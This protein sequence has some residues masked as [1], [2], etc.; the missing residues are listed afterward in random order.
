MESPPQME[1]G[2]E[3]VE[4]QSPFTLAKTGDFERLMPVVTKDPSLWSQR[5]EGDEHTLLHWAALGADAAFLQ[6]GLDSRAEVDARSANGQTP[7]MWAALRGRLEAA[8]LLLRAGA[9]IYGKDSL[10][11][12]PMVLA[13]QHQQHAMMVLLMAKGDR[14]R[15]LVE[16][17]NN[18]CGPVHWAAYKG[19]ITSL[20]LLD[21]FDADMSVVDGTRM[22]PLHRAVQA[23]KGDVLEFL[24]DKQV[25]PGAIDSQGHT[26]I[27]LA[28]ENGDKVMQRMLTKL[29]E[30]AGAADLDFA[31]G[32]ADPE[33]AGAILKR[34]KPDP[35]DKQ[36]DDYKKM[37]AHNGAAT[38][39]LVSV[40]LALFQYLTDI[41]TVSWT[42][43][44]TLA[45]MFELGVP[46][47]I[48][49]FFTVMF[50][51]PGKVPAR[52]KNNSA[53]E[54]YMK[55]VQTDVKSADFSKI[56]TTTWVLKG[57][58]TK[59]CRR[60][61]ACVDEFDHFCGWLN[62]AIGKGNH[63]AFVILALVE[64]STQFIHLALCW[65]AACK[66]VPNE[67]S[68]VNWQLGIWTEYPLTGL[69]MIMHCFTSPGIM[70]LFLNH[71]RMVAVNITTNEMMNL[72]RYGHFWKMKA[73][74]GKEFDNPFDK[75]TWAS[76]C[77]D[78]WWNRRRGVLG[79]SQTLDGRLV[80][81]QAVMV[82]NRGG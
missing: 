9:D 81:P 58:R 70:F 52:R 69:L 23:S 6:H 82:G 75:G 49:L 71:V 29:L 40:S 78:F 30:G 19:D 46:L 60:T 66:L 61:G 27:D 68:V 20:R 5:E 13:V 24:L 2:A 41:R 35:R 38:C 65:K 31:V 1:I 80:M 79:P 67:S 74:G 36:M 22:T 77:L 17:D 43:A 50:L 72:Y 33:A 11:A 34:R 62:T 4:A 32:A 3:M 21:Y 51:D 14:D 47:S 55:A 73:N 45:L 48:A 54:D 15:L 39:W 44:P 16:S 59:Y 57:P 12:T 42:V 26:V 8:D 7:L 64:F 63:R 76:N 56:C 53:I 28:N 25:D 10:G 18:G 37:A